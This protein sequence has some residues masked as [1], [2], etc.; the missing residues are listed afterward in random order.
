MAEGITSSVLKK[1]TNAEL[2]R[3]LCPMYMAMGMTYHE[4]WDDDAELVR[5]YQKA[6]KEKRRMVNWEAWLY[7]MYTYS[8]FS[9][10]YSNAWQKGSKAKYPEKPIPLTQEDARR[11]KEEENRLKMERL[12]AYMSNK[13]TIQKELAKQEKQKEAQD[14]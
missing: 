9:T 10:V 14:G 8:A 3:E 13:M 12:Y 6:Y 11:E 7:G 1:K 2:F 5:F 4:F